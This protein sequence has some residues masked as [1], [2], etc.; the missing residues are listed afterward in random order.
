M[1]QEKKPKSKPIIKII[2]AVVLVAVLAG[3]WW[4]VKSYLNIGSD[5]YTNAAQ[6]E[7]FINPVNARVS[8]YI[9]EIRFIEHQ[10]VKAGDTLIVLDDREILTQVGQAEAALNNALAAKNTTNSSVRTVTN[11][12]NTADA[13]VKAAKSNIDAA[14]ARLWNIEQN[15]NRYKV[16]L[17]E[18]AITGQ[19]YD[20]IVA[21]YEAQKAQIEALTSQY[22]SLLNAKS[23][24]SLTVEEVKARI[25]QNDA[26]IQRAQNALDMAK[27][28]LSYCYIVAPHD[29][30][31]GR[32]TVNEGQLL[33]MP[34][35]QVATLV[36]DREKWV[37]AN[38]REKQMHEIELGKTVK[39]KVDALNG[40]EYEMAV[41]A[42]SGATGA[43]YAA[44]PVDNATGNFVKV[45]QRI[46]VRLEFT[47]KNAK[48]DLALLRAGMNVEVFVK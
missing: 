24:T 4:A 26:E 40:K 38:F 19:Q 30:I 32:R 44:V 28:N 47:D 35:Q 34:G 36:D 41:T 43:R 48:E 17:K 15:Y 6:V 27:L 46:P 45:Q 31:M 14:K 7:T 9:K 37:S 10:K 11:N 23:T 13:N 21:E 20:Q 29:G 25:G 18:E 22:N 12:V 3:L 42:V 16:L 5:S 39:I 1:S 33:T 8:A 2:N